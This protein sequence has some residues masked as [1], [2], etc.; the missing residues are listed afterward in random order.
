[1]DW[2]RKVRKNF[3]PEFAQGRETYQKENLLKRLVPF[4]GTLKYTFLRRR[5]ALAEGFGEELR[6][7]QRLGG[8]T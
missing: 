2:E 4:P 1:M 8:E 7:A 6:I 3:Y 5:G